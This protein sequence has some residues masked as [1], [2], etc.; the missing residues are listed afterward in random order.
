MSGNRVYV[1]GNYVDVHD[2]EVVNLTIDKVGVLELEKGE[3]KPAAV[4]PSVLAESDLWAR[5]KQAGWVNDDGQPTVSRTEA[6]LI[7]NELAEKLGIAHK[8]KLFEGMW[9]RNNMRGDYNKALEQEKSLV[10]Q[11]KLKKLFG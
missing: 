11:D 3:Q 9:H 4:I 7:A 6:A 1:Q 2:N 10:F 5:V 8:W